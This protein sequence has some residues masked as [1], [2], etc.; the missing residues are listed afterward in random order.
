MLSEH[1]ASG[2]GARGAFS[3]GQSDVSE[4]VGFA[5]A[6]APSLMPITHEWIYINRMSMPFSLIPSSVIVRNT[7]TGGILRPRP[8]RSVG[9]G[10][11]VHRLLV[12]APSGEMGGLGAIR[13][14][15]TPVGS[16]HE[17]DSRY[18]WARGSGLI[19]P[20]AASFVMRLGPEPVPIQGPREEGRLNA[21]VNADASR[22]LQE[23]EP[24]CPVTCGRRWTN[25][26][27]VRQGIRTIPR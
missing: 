13:I 25:P 15:R 19:G 8:S 4:P 1:R 7:G 10:A 22:P 14:G 12:S 17:S 18:V 27:Q 2:R 24:I 26:R 20:C 11:W 23:G 21:E 5:S 6:T 9:V 3:G 16:R